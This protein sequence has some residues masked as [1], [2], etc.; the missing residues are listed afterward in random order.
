MPYTLLVQNF[1]MMIQSTIEIEGK[2]RAKLHHDAAA[3][4]QHLKEVWMQHSSMHK[5]KFSSSEEKQQAFTKPAA[6]LHMSVIARGNQQ[7]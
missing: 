1:W 7:L 2:R 4:R 6:H 5:S 3:D